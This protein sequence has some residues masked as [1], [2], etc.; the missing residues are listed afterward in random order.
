MNIK[1]RMKQLH[2][3]LKAYLDWPIPYWISPLGIFVISA[4][5]Y[6]YSIAYDFAMPST[7]H[8][9]LD[10]TVFLGGI[11]MAALIAQN[12]FNK[13][14]KQREDRERRLKRI[15][16]I[17]VILELIRLSGM[18][19]LDCKINSR[20]QQ[21]RSLMGDI[22][23][24]RAF[25]DIYFPGRTSTD[26]LVTYVMKLNYDSSQEVKKEDINNSTQI[27]SLENNRDRDDLNENPL[28]STR[29]RNLLKEVSDIHREIEET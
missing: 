2:A 24:V 28:L 16:D 13:N 22:V 7:I 23:K 19:F 26:E 4:L 3:K 29:I 5:S 11:L 9:I 27:R 1:N 10:K 6:L 15:E 12:V 21:Y 14:A 25:R 17:I 8:W 20:T 18:E